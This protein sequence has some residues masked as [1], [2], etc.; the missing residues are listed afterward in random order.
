M[1]GNFLGAGLQEDLVA[2]LGRIESELGSSGFGWENVLYVHLYIDDM[3]QFCVAN[4]T[5]VKFITYE[6]CPFG[7]PSRSTVELPLHQLRLGRAFVEVLVTKTQTKKV[8]HVQSISR[9]APSCIG[10]YS[11]VIF[12]PRSSVC[13]TQTARMHL[14]I[15]VLHI[16]VKIEYIIYFGTSYQTRPTFV[17]ER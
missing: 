8:L 16:I 3:T 1:L 9:W 13:I 5:Y 10:P 7:V 17:L 12:V 15:S 6:N 2:V 14:F 4:D 11:Q